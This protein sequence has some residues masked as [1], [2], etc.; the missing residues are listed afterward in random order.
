VTGARYAEDFEPGRE[1]ACGSRVVTAADVQAFAALSGD[2]NPLHVSEPH[3]TAGE[4]GRPIAHGVLGVAV[5]TGL[6]SAAGLTAHC[7]VAL[8]GL[9]WRFAAPVHD[10][11]ELALRVRVAGR[12]FSA[13]PGRAVVTFAAT[14]TNQHGVVVQDGELTELLRTRR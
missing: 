1:F 4:F 10:G 2:R 12:R 8:V 14:L 7:L 13:R 3:A 5:A 6:M 9:T 11:D